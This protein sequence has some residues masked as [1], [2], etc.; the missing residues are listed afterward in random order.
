M[1]HQ[2]AADMPLS[3]CKPRKKRPA[4]TPLAICIALAPLALVLVW[5]ATEL[6]PELLRK[7]L[8]QTLQPTTLSALS[9]RSARC[10]RAVSAIELLRAQTLWPEVQLAALVSHLHLPFP[11][12][13][14]RAQLD[15]GSY[16]Y[17]V[18]CAGLTHARLLKTE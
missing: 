13:R 4:P 9:S 8:Q 10:T 6:L 17:T 14:D 12:G 7:T 2:P 3:G 1:G 15:D 11:R 5:R 16:C 18:D